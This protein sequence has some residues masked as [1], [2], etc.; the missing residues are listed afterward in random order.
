MKFELAIVALSVLL[1]S[2]S[3]LQAQN[4]PLV[5]P[6]VTR[7]GNPFD[8]FRYFSATLN[9]G[10]TRDTNRRIYRSGNLIRL[11]FDGSYRI[12]D[13]E[14]VMTWGVDPHACVQIALPDAGTFPF[15]AYRDF[16]VERALT[17]EKETVDGHLCAI[18]NVTFL[19]PDSRPL[20]VKMKLWEAEDLDRFPVKIEVEP[21]DPAGRPI[22]KVTLTYSNVSLRPPDEGL[23][24]HPPNCT[25]G[26]QPGS[27]GTLNLR[28]PAG[29]SKPAP[30]KP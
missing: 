19:P 29:L 5:A 7:G 28:P 22:E 26:A 10:I 9:G 13:L 1:L 27:K 15:S 16:K 6:P 18:E 3:A 2:A 12:T 30:S 17:A 20:V 8:S 11:D 24:Q 14:K 21:T 25:M 4:A 23:F